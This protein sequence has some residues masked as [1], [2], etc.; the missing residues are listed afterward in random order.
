M[1]VRKV[2]EKLLNGLDGN[3]MIYIYI[4]EL[5]HLNKDAQVRHDERIRSTKE[6]KNKVLDQLKL[7]D[8]TYRVCINPIRSAYLNILNPVILARCNTI[9]SSHRS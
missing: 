3:V 4:R 1:E 2:E 8:V 7:P 5:P 9:Y 6:S